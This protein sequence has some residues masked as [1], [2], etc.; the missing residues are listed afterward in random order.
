[1]TSVDALSASGEV[2]CARRRPTSGTVTRIAFAASLR[3]RA[4]TE[5]SRRGG[6]S[7]SRGSPAEPRPVGFSRATRGILTDRHAVILAQ[8]LGVPCRYPFGIRSSQVTGRAKKISGIAVTQAAAGANWWSMA[9][10]A[11]MIKARRD[12]LVGGISI[13]AAVSLL[14]AFRGNSVRAKSS[15]SP[16]LP[17]FRVEHTEAEWRA[18]L[19]PARFEV[20][21]RAGTEYPFSSPLDREARAGAYACAGCRTALYASSTKFDS[22]T[23]WPSFFQPLPNA[24]LRA[25]DDS[26]GVRRTEIHCATCGGHLGHVFPDGPP[27]TGL[28]YCMNG[29]ALL[30][31]PKTA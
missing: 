16:S 6:S 15:V 29:I 11:T 22:G 8:A 17:I 13:L 23:G 26:F 5:P 9:R 10:A 25:S 4:R 21:R 14:E 28:R 7:R 12:L 27:P 31:T 24:V 20:M 1:M 3:L 2:S 18:L 19:G 30:F